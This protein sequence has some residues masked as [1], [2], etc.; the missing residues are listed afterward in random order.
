MD[1]IK[2]PKCW[3]AGGVWFLQPKG[4][5]QSPP[6]ISPFSCPHCL[7]LPLLLPLNIIIMNNKSGLV[8]LINKTLPPQSIFSLHQQCPKRCAGDGVEVGK[9]GPEPWG[10][11]SPLATINPSQPYIPLRWPMVSQM[12]ARAVLRIRVQ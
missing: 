12:P 11:W 2:L 3:W 7:L 8:S 5:Q 6:S 4:S 9:G 10:L 1:R